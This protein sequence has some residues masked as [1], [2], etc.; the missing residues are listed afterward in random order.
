MGQ[1]LKYQSFSLLVL[2]LLSINYGICQIDRATV[3]FEE[4][5]SLVVPQPD[6][7]LRR[8]NLQLEK[9]FSVKDTIRAIRFKRMIGGFYNRR[10]D[11]SL[12]MQH[13]TEALILSEKINATLEKAI[14]LNE[15]GRMQ[16]RFGDLEVALDYAKQAHNLRKKCI[17]KNDCNE[18]VLIPSYISFIHIARQRDDHE[19]ALKYLDSCFS[20]S[21]SIN[22]SALEKSNLDQIKASILI[23]Q[24]NLSKSKQILLQL[25]KL[26]DS[27]L[28]IDKQNLKVI[29]HKIS[30]QYNIGKIYIKEKQNALALKNYESALNLIRTYNI[31]H[32]YQPTLLEQI[33][34]L[35]KL[36]KNYE[37]AHKYLLEAKTLEDEF[38][39]M[40]SD[41]SKEFLKL[42]DGYQ[43]LLETQQQELI[44][45]QLELSEKEEAILRFRILVLIIL[46]CGV[47]GIF[48]IKN[49]I[50][51]IKFRNK[52]DLLKQRAKE[53][54]NEAKLKLEYKNKELTSYALQLMERDDL[55]DQFSDFV[56]DSDRKKEAKS[57]IV[58]RKQL[59][60]NAWEEFEKRFVEVNKSFYNNLSKA[61][62]DLTVND[63]RYAALLKLN[64]SGKE[65]SKLLGVTEKSVHM[66][67]YRIRK[68]FELKTD[69]NLVAFLN[70]F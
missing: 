31:K 40:N 53:K 42:R 63:L 58:A 10:L 37:Q 43:E 57:L 16:R 39:R 12:A 11:F 9:A 1:R 29:D 28:S 8:Y 4:R 60:G 13:F 52:E 30:Q 65:I 46:L 64:L 24:G 38:F 50:A 34:S 61:Y 41:K 25:E 36:Q 69:D 15:I 49:R 51:K 44:E 48:L 47:I 3:L 45:N 33:S 55:L 2:S 5:D 18:A 23:D 17:A 56:T 35:Y 20:I 54:Q 27:L 14:T 62:P 59:V 68:K 70:K 7:V 22:Q 6:S 32:N 26:Y 66:A 19:L 67:R 21:N